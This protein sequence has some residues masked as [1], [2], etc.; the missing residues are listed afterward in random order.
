MYY[1][2]LLLA[3]VYRELVDGE[4]TLFALIDTIFICC[5]APGCKMALTEPLPLSATPQSNN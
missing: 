1:C 4:R 3:V 5:E 2:Q